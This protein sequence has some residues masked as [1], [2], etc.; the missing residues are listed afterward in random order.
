[1]AFWRHLRW[2]LFCPG[3]QKP[4]KIHGMEGF[5]RCPSSSKKWSSIANKT[6]SVKDSIKCIKLTDNLLF[7]FW[8]PSFCCPI[9]QGRRDPGLHFAAG[10]AADLCGRTAAERPGDVA[11]AGRTPRGA[12]GL[13]H[14][15]GGRGHARGT[16]VL[17]ADAQNTRWKDEKDMRCFEVLS[18]LLWKRFKDQSLWFFRTF[19]EIYG[20]LHFQS[21]PHVGCGCWLHGD[22]PQDAGTVDLEVP[23]PVTAK[24]KEIGISF[25]STLRSVPKHKEPP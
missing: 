4:L 21:S 18:C 12:R 6:S 13:R 7:I 19:V 9:H 17:G 1:M 23:G 2:A 11:D 20:T 15:H 8:I 5:S 14:R 24:L 3:A 25:R 10:A 22:R 16:R